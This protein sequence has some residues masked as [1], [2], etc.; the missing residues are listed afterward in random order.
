MP[1]IAL[2]IPAEVAAVISAV[3]GA[4]NTAQSLRNVLAK[5]PE[6]P[7]VLSSLRGAYTHLKTLG[8]LS[9]LWEKPNLQ[10]ACVSNAFKP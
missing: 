4:Q 3:S 10:Q 8:W 5:P 7:R 6:L 1:L 2:P 9:L